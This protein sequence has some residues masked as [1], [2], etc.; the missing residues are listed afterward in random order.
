MSLCIYL[1]NSKSLVLS[2]A[3]FLQNRFSTN[4]TCCCILCT[5]AWFFVNDSI[6][7]L[8]KLITFVACSLKEQQ[9]FLIQSSPRYELCPFSIVL[10]IHIVDI[11]EPQGICSPI[12]FVEDFS[13]LFAH[14][15]IFY[16][17][18]QSQHK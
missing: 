15:S 14:P 16:S 5:S 4:V 18:I 2:L 6:F 9:N 8:S 12:F 3:I 1:G 13:R 10:K 7:F 11:D 17:K